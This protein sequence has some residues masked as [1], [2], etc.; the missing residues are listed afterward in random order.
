MCKNHLKSHYGLQRIRNR[1]YTLLSTF[2]LLTLCLTASSVFAVGISPPTTTIDPL[3]SKPILNQASQ[4]PTAWTNRIPNA[5]ATYYTYVPYSNADAIALGFP[6]TCGNLNLPS[7]EDQASTDDCYSIVAKDV[8]HQLSHD[9]I[10]GG[11]QGLL[12][13]VG[14]PFG[15][16]TRAY[17]YGSGGMSWTPPGAAVA[18]TGNAPTP[19]VDGTYGTQGM[20]D[21]PGPSIKATK[22]RPVRV[23]WLNDISP[24]VAPMGLDPTVDCGANTDY[25]YPYNRI[26]SHVHGAHVG[27]ESD[28]TPNQWFTPLFT[29]TG[30]DWV[31]TSVPPYSYGPKGTSYYPM[32]QEAG[33]IWYHDHAMG[34][35]HH[36]VNMGLAGFFPI[37]DDNEKC[38]QGQAVPGCTTAPTKYL[39]T[40]NYELG[41]A[42]QDRTFTSDA[43]LALYDYPIY[44]LTTPGCTMLP[45]GVPNPS[46]CR[47]LDW[48][49]SLDGTHL[50]PYVAGAPELA[51]PQNSLAPLPAP[52]TSL[53]F[54]GNMPMVN[55]VTYG[56]QN[57]EAQVY[58]MRFIGGTDSRTWIMQ[59]KVSSS[60]NPALVGQIIPFYQIATEQGFVSTP[61]LRQSMLLMPGERLD[62]LVDLTGLPV[63][64]K[65]DML[66]LGPDMPYNAGDPLIDPSQMPSTDIPKIME[67]DVTAVGTASVD[68]LPAAI[69]DLRPISGIIDPL[70][71]TAGTSV[72]KVS[73]MEIKDNLGR[74]LPTID[75]RGYMPMGVPITEVAINGDT[76]TWDIINTTADAHPMH[77]HLVAFQVIH[78][79][80]FTT[81]TKPVTSPM[82]GV[83][84]QPSYTAVPGTE[85]L[86]GDF[87]KGW[88]DTV[89]CPPGYVTR[90][91]AKFDISGTYVW[92]CHILSHEEH[93][94]MRP[95]A[96][97]DPITDVA[98]TMSAASPRFTNAGPVTITATG[99]TGGA[100][101]PVQSI[102]PALEYRFSTSPAT[103]NLWS[104]RQ[105]FSPANA[106]NW[107]IATWGQGSYDIKIDVRHVGSTHAT[108]ATKIISGYQ[109]NT[110]AVKT[111]TLASTASAATFA[112]GPLVTFTAA[113]SG[114]L[115]P[116]EYQFWIQDSVG[117]R[118]VKDYNAVSP[119]P[120][121]IWKWDTSTAATGTNTI[122][123]YAR[124]A[125]STKPYELKRSITYT[126]VTN[127]LAT[128][129]TLTSNA[130]GTV[131]QQGA[132]VTFT[133]TAAGGTAPYQFQY[134]L[135]F[136][137]A[138]PVE[139]K[140]YTVGNNT[141]LW[142][143]T[144]IAAG[145]Y[146]VSVYARSAGS[147]AAYEISRSLAF[148]VVTNPKVTSVLLSSNAPGAIFTKGPSVTFTATAQNGTAPYEYQFKLKIGTAA[149][150][151]VKAYRTSTPDTNTWL[152]DTSLYPTGKYS[153]TVYARS[154]GSVAT[155]EA[156]KVLSFT[157][158]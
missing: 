90:V 15:A 21:F 98:Y 32:S 143:T 89:S 100:G 87:D 147:V 91:R 138:A 142:D 82:T 119:D 6:S 149:P 75:A 16:I 1:L 4:A 23:Q 135:K 49:Y 120:A 122:S 136:G 65:I 140:A 67:I 71:Q 109:L 154:G 150:V 93:D 103:R 29:T 64:T 60:P 158:N 24:N 20:W 43:Q 52:N 8:L 30:A 115:A 46:T 35:T 86:P 31:D 25:C 94:M 10:L 48:M 50:I 131:F 51:I 83:F 26:T 45:S 111:L 34:T 139:V 151:E 153:I 58:R 3:Y 95:M 128:S 130:P 81:F 157:V 61:I 55:G 129:G 14:A 54:F 68:V 125:G 127:S 85:I 13:S 27:S 37:T 97:V 72:R 11:G 156:T 39:P 106:W 70:V 69:P 18:V 124:Y 59:L 102:A 36:N 84:K 105:D 88:K 9:T 118:V 113:A 146:T 73:L 41:Y 12:N 155:S 144:G 79:Q 66:N 80:P 62:A 137:T 17:G 101:G 22:G 123:V 77:L 56:V 152:W 33:T 145:N 117:L 92:H 134:K 42:L 78:R 121:N 74:T 38:L 2:F 108:D 107:A 40:G 63:G 53:E 5:L 28:G 76:E 126:V 44:D 57:V 99:V 132:A 112:K 133:A 96:V 7:A 116:Y 110:P 104:V 141:W 47:R 19:F 114:G 148:T